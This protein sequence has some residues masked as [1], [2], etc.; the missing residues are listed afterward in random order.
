MDDLMAAELANRLL[1]GYPS[2]RPPSLTHSLYAEYLSRVPEEQATV[3][4]E[5]AFSAYPHRPPQLG[6]LLGLLDIARREML[7][8][9]EPEHVVPATPEEARAILGAWGRRVDHEATVNED[10]SHEHEAIPRP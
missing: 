3:A 10:S 1:A 2:T 5:R 6:E 9:G 8:P 7:P 4:V